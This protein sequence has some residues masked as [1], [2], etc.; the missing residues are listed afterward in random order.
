MQ[1]FVV[2]GILLLSRW[3][4][5]RKVMREEKV[6]VVEKQKCL[7][8]RILVFLYVQFNTIFKKK[9]VVMIV[10]KVRITKRHCKNSSIK[11]NSFRHQTIAGAIHAK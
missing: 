7:E 1:R 2:S 10:H 11:I 4:K 3:Y 9:S 5:L 8:V 6:K